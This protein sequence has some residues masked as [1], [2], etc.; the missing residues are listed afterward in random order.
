MDV[1]NL[2]AEWGCV[3]KLAERIIQEEERI[4][5]WAELINMIS[6]ILIVAEETTDASTMFFDVYQYLFRLNFRVK[7]FGSPQEFNQVWSTTRVV[8]QK[9]GKKEFY[10]ISNYDYRTF[11]WAKKKGFTDFID[12]NSIFVPVSGLTASEKKGLSKKIKNA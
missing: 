3:T 7:A 8:S 1:H 4:G 9:E 2:E 5:G 11:I 12:N 6:D 10:M